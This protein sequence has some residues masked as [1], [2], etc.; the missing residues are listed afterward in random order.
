MRSI[1][2]PPGFNPNIYFGDNDET[3][4]QEGDRCNHTL[5]GHQAITDKLRSYS[6]SNKTYSQPKI[7]MTWK[8]KQE[9]LYRIYDDGKIPVELLDGYHPNDRGSGS[10]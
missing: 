7:Q 4:N 2:M 3:N 1:P 8:E 6:S 10:T 5:I 9:L